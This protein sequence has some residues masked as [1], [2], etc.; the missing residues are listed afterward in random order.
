MQSRA[1]RRLQDPGQMGARSF[2]GHALHTL[3]ATLESS[4][5]PACTESGL[6]GAHCGWDVAPWSPTAKREQK[7]A[8]RDA[9]GDAALFRERSGLSASSF[10]AADTSRDVR[11]PEG[12]KLARRLPRVEREDSMQKSHRRQRT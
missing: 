8:V 5:S 12:P 4:G 6:Q 7:P 1:V 10:C 9:A 2:V 11:E 3:G